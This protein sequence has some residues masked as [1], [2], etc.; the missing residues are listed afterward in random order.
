MI[1]NLPSGYGVHRYADD[2]DVYEGQFEE[3]RPSGPGVL[4]RADE[5]VIQEGRWL[6]G[7][8]VGK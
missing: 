4:R 3:G 5:T 8:Y 6:D 2:G 7:E 1:N